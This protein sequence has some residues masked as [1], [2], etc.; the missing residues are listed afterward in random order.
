MTLVSM[1]HVIRIQISELGKHSFRLA[2]STLKS[3]TDFDN[4]YHVD[5]TPLDLTSWL[6]DVLLPSMTWE[7]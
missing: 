7:L 5:L 2:S 1:F 4:R 6:P 3:I